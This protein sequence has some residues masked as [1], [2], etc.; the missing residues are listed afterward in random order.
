M[1]RRN[2][3]PPSSGSKNKPNQKKN[4]LKT[5]VKQRDWRILRRLKWRQYI[6]PK[7]LL[8]FN[9]LHGVISQNHRC[10]KLKSYF[11]LIFRLLSIHMTRP[12]HFSLFILIYLFTSG[13]SYCSLYSRCYAVIVRWTDIPDPFP[14]NGSP[15]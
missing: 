11:L 3:F 6:P 1:F 9:V 7:R 4:S 14:D 8:N 10:K 2:I 12:V 15:Y 5:G 13:S